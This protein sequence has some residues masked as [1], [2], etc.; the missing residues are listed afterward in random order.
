LSFLKLRA[1]YDISLFPPTV[2][3]SFIPALW[4]GMM[5]AGTRPA[6]TEHAPRS[7]EIA[8]HLSGAGNDKKRRTRKDNKVGAGNDKKSEVLAMIPLLSLRGAEGDEAISCPWRLPR[9]ARNDK[10]IKGSQ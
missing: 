5:W 8:A 10:E 6:P 1:A 4:V 3:A 2:K 7:P 9:F